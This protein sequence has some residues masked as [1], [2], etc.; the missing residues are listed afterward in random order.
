[1]QPWGALIV[2]PEAVELELATASVLSRALAR[3]LDLLASALALLV[4]ALLAS[5]LPSPWGLALLSV[6]VFMVVLGYPVLFETFGRGRTLGKL[7]VGLRVLGDDG[8][9]IGLREAAVRG[10]L[11]ILDIFATSGSLA[12]IVTLISSRDQRLGDMAAGTLVVRV[13][14]RQPVE[15]VWLYPPPGC[16]PI[17]ASLDIGTMVPADYEVVR[18]FLVRWPEF[19][20]AQRLALARQLAGPLWQRFR[21]QLPAGFPPDLY[22]AC[23][24]CAFQRQRQYQ[25]TAGQ[26]T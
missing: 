15:P 13:G 2:T 16:E 9:P 3:G 18:A 1:M 5:V 26:M 19:A 10:A 21:H 14:R 25:Y 20:P 4:L 17:V 24:G 22:L 11:G 7:V 12:V 6:S 23:L 8:G